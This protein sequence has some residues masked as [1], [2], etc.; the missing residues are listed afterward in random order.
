ME[1]QQG[2]GLQDNSGAQQSARAKE[3][4]PEPEEDPVG[5]KEVG[6]SPA[7]ALQN[8]KL[9]FEKEVFGQHGFDASGPEN[10][11]D[12]PTEKSEQHGGDFHE[13][14]HWTAMDS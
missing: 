7:G 9:V 10:L 4:G 3:Q 14:A 2:G 11:D 5:R 6:C 13:K 12:L 8:Q 1:A